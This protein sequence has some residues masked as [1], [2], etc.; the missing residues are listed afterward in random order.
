[1]NKREALKLKP[2]IHVRCGNSAMTAKVTHWHIARVQHVT[3]KGGVLVWSRD[4]G[5]RWVPY[6]HILAIARDVD[7]NGDWVC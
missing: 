5:E 1:M 2:G 4:G 3:P 7:A 6:H